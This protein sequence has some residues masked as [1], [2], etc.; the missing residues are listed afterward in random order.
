MQL[1]LLDLTDRDHPCSAKRNRSRCIGRYGDVDRVMIVAVVRTLVGIGIGA[2]AAVVVRRV[3]GDRCRLADQVLVGDIKAQIAE[4][5]RCGAGQSCSRSGALGGHQVV[6]RI[7]IAWIGQEVLDRDLARGGIVSR[8]LDIHLVLG[9]VLFVLVPMHTIRADVGAGLVAVI[10]MLVGQI[11]GFG[12]GDHHALGILDDGGRIDV[13]ACQVGRAGLVGMAGQAGLFA[14]LCLPVVSLRRRCDGARVA[15]GAVAQVLREADFGETYLGV[16]ISPDRVVLAAGSRLLRLQ[17][18]AGVDL[19][20]HRRQVEVITAVGIDGAGV[21]AHHAKL[22]V[23]T[24]AT[25]QCE[26]LVARI[27]G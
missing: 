26:L 21:V 4:L 13:V 18:L 11:R 6:G 20:N 1:G 10:A 15:F 8:T 24:S 23:Y 25:V 17:Q 5:G 2:A 3:L 9:A 12:C 22:R 7:G 19:V 14:D 16:V 27:A